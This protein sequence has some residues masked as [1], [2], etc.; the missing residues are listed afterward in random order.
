MNVIDLQ[1]KIKDDLAQINPE[2]LPI[3]AVFIEFIKSKQGQNLGASINYPSASE[4]SI[5]RDNKQSLG[6]DLDRREKA[7]LNLSLLMDKASEEAQSN[8]LNPDILQGI[9]DEDE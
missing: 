6:D 1:D 9:L 3:I 7:S 8:G 2:N 5:F 4:K